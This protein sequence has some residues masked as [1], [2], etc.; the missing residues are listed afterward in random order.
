MK[1][2]PW[3]LADF[4]DAVAKGAPPVDALLS[5]AYVPDQVEVSTDGMK[6]AFTISTGAIDRDHDT[7]SADGWDLAA[8]RQNPV[9]LWSHDTKGLPIAKSVKTWIAAGALKSVCEFPPEGVYPFADSVRGLVKGGFIKGTSVGFHPIEFEPRQMAGGVTRGV[10]FKRQELYEYSIL[11]VPSNRE[12]LAEAKRAGIA[13]APVVEWCQAFVETAGKGL[14]L[15]ADDITKALRHLRGAQVSVP[16]LPSAETVE[17]HA[18]PGADAQKGGAAFYANQHRAMGHGNHDEVMAN[19][20][21]QALATGSTTPEK[22]LAHASERASAAAEARLTA[23]ELRAA[24]S[25]AVGDGVKARRSSIADRLAKE[26]DGHE[27]EANSV[28]EALRRHGYVPPEVAGAGVAAPATKSAPP[29]P[30]KKKPEGDP[31]APA[32]PKPE[33]AASAG[34]AS[35][36]GDPKGTIDPGDPN[37]NSDGTEAGLGATP[38]DP[39]RAADMI[40]AL[41]HNLDGI[42]AMEGD[43]ASKATALKAALEGF[44]VTFMDMVSTTGQ[45]EEGAIGDPAGQPDPFAPDPNDPTQQATNIGQAG[46]GT[47]MMPQGGEASVHQQALHPAAVSTG[48]SVVA[49]PAVPAG[50]KRKPPAKGF[51]AELASLLPQLIVEKKAGGGTQP[52]PGIAPRYVPDPKRVPSPPDIW[53]DPHPIEDPPITGPARPRVPRPRAPNPRSPR[54]PHYTP[55]DV[56]PD[57][58]PIEDPPIHNGKPAAPSKPAARFRLGS[59]RRAPDGKFR[60]GIFVDIVTGGTGDGSGDSGGTA[61]GS[62]PPWMDAQAGDGDGA[63]NEADPNDPQSDAKPAEDKPAADP[64]AKPVATAVASADPTKPK[65]DSKPPWSKEAPAEVAKI[66][67]MLPKSDKEQ[68]ADYVKANFGISMQEFET[69]FK[70]GI[71]ATVREAMSQHR[72]VTTGRLPD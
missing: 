50:P 42:V 40:V 15:P 71:A 45:E 49:V 8:Y 35:T 28:H 37:A 69:G 34:S 21:H 68:A 66:A 5:K 38:V 43:D 20:F 13:I 27:M 52:D 11:P 61:D 6:A 55:P 7:V 12:A 36:Q 72:V 56:W 47:V 44:G 31:A 54:D 51:E 23:A 1:L 25:G 57:P 4:K 39:E 9:V 18:G 48:Q 70:G 59:L 33:P 58:H 41:A 19:R 67:A 3:K 24:A 62:T 30:P 60:K 22:V 46:D 65:P 17:G 16:G 64:A 53:P 14:W 10:S 29:F 32:S 2:V 26:G 63:D